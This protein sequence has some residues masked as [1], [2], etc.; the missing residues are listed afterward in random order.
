MVESWREKQERGLSGWQQAQPFPS[1]QYQGPSSQDCYCSPQCL[2]RLPQRKM[3]G[4]LL[5]LG[6]LRFIFSS[7]WASAPMALSLH[8]KGR[9]SH[10]WVSRSGPGAH[11]TEAPPASLIQ[12]EN[13]AFPAS[14]PHWSL[15][16][17]RLVVPSQG[18][19]SGQMVGSVWRKCTWALD[20]DSC[21]IF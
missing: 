14:L 1:C 18:P 21:S 7:S 6:L 3:A 4:R 19:G 5:P 9:S 12:D 15:M 8:G 2:S 20:P 11:G 10:L 13:G 16:H 17:N